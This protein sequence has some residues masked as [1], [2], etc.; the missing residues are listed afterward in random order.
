MN[1]PHGTDQQ[2]FFCNSASYSSPH[3][4]IKNN[5]LRA[6]HLNKCQLI[7]E[8]ECESAGPLDLSIKKSTPSPQ[9]HTQVQ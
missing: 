5:I 7:K 9:L 1:S 4:G 8:D 2:I 6:A 3:H